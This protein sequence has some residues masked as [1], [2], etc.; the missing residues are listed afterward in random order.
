MGGQLGGHD[1]TLDL[2]HWVNDGLMTLFFFV[3]GLEIKREFVEGELNG[4]RCAVLPVCAA[5]GGM[6]VPAA[7]FALVNQSGAGSRG[8]GIPMAT[9]IAL[10]RGVLALSGSGFHSSLKLFLLALALAIMDD[11]GA[12]VVIAI[13]YSASINIAMFAASGASLA[14]M[15][16]LKRVGVRPVAVYTIIGVA[17]WVTAH[18]GGI[19]AAIAGV[20]A[21]LLAP[22]RPFV[23]VELVDEAVL[24]DVSTVQATHETVRL[25]GRRSRWLNGLSTACTRGPVS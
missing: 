12:I 10:A 20:V 13:F 8:W 9:D 2:R 23:P 6:M 25:A 17:M 19:H 14:L 21:G 15:V 24:A 22:A 3:V 7:L 18:E 1:L 4:V 11:V 16:V 5:F